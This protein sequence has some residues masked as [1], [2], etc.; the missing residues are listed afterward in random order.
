MTAATYIPLSKTLDVF[1]R[2]E[3]FAAM[4]VFATLGLVLMAVSHNLATFCAAYVRI[5]KWRELKSV[6][7]EFICL[8]LLLHWVRRHDILY[9]RHYCRC[10][11]VEEPR[12][13]FRLHIVSIHHHCFRRRQS[14]RGFLLRHQLA[15]GIWCILDH[16]PRGRCSSILHFEV[17]PKE[18]QADRRP[19]RGTKQPGCIRNNLV[20]PCPVR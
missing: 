14:S 16:F 17:Q 10:I 3:G 9:R 15:L 19:A 8:G 1:G 5:L 18:G 7:N 20:L 12:S 2:A 13:G 6:T 11:Q 4:T